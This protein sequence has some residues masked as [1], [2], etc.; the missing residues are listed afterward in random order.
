MKNKLKLFGVI[1]AVLALTLTECPDP[2]PEPK[3]D[4]DQTTVAVTGV[5]LNKTSTT[6]LVNGTETL[7]ATVAPDNATNKAVTWSTSNAAIATVNEG[8]VTAKAAGTATITVTTADGN[9]TATCA[10]T[11]TAPITTYTV[12]YNAN[13][14]SGTMANSE[15]TIGASKALTANGFTKT[16]NLFVCWTTNAGGTGTKYY[17]SQSVTDLTT[18]TTTVTLYAQWAEGN[19]YY[20]VT[21]ATALNYVKGT[22][23]TTLAQNAWNNAVA[24]PTNNSNVHITTITKPTEITVEFSGYN[25]WFVLVP[26]SLGE[27]IIKD[28]GGVPV[29]STFPKNDATYN[30]VKYWLHQGGS[31]TGIQNGLELKLSY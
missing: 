23:T 25:I 28:S 2:K 4:P 17:N 22:N 24:N 12:I 30:G 31:S 13:G 1:T 7:T 11:V 21:S 5:T 6:I 19:M 18:T 29:T 3:P 8:T 26:Q 15:H 27:L 20:G 9:K 14:G 16:D 10:V